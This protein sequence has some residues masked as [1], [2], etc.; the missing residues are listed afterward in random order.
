[1]VV[2]RYDECQWVL[3]DPR[4]GKGEPG[5]VWEGY[6]LT[7]AEWVD[8]FGDFN[9]RSRSML[10]LDPP[11]H[12]RLRR[13]VAKAFT[14]KTVETLRPGIVR[15]TRE[16]LDGFGGGSN[17][18]NDGVVD[19]IG[20]LAMTLPVA[21]IG[22]MLG[23]PDA[24]RVDLQPLVRDAVAVLEINPTLAQIEAAAA[25]YEGH[26]GSVRGPH[27]GAACTPDR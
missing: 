7:E 22:E 6:G 13:L 23:V 25:R 11:D 17:G 18:S 20:E 12:T 1:M 3:R 8:R 14:P 24:D 27:R 4:F 15:L 26:R 2:G 16:I 10:G 21:V 9:Q 19:V 5:P